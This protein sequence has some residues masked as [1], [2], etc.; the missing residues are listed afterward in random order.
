MIF[1]GVSNALSH[2]AESRLLVHL[3]MLLLEIEL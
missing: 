1:A 3:V 2:I